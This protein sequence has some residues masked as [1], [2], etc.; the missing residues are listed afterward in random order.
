MFYSET[1]L[2]TLMVMI[3]YIALTNF[4]IVRKKKIM[5]IIKN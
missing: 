5:K 4:L 3:L 1:F 2:H